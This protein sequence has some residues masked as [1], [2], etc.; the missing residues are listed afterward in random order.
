MQSFASLVVD[1]DISELIGLV[2]TRG[3]FSR[4][5]VVRTGSGLRLQQCKFFNNLVLLE[6]GHQAHVAVGILHCHK[7]LVG[8]MAI[9]CVVTCGCDDGDGGISW[10]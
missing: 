5:I 2:E 1:D 8:N 7:G 10:F 6:S 3:L 9:G 4:L